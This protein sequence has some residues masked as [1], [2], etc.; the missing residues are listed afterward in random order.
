MSINQIAG[1]QKHYISMNVQKH[2]L[3]FWFETH[4][5]PYSGKL[6]REKTFVNFAFLC[7]C[8]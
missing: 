8:A 6:L 5:L 1:Y 3:L 2:P 7:L 4:Q